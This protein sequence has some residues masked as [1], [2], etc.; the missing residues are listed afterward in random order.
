MAT[1]DVI[2]SRERESQKMS[3]RRLADLS[4]VAET[5]L[6]RIEG[7]QSKSTPADLQKIALALHINPSKLIEAWLKES[8]EGI[9]YNPALL[10]QIRKPDME[11][12]QVEA[13]Y[14]IDQAR[15]AYEKIRSC[16]TGRKMKELKQDTLVEVRVAL[17]NCLGFIDDLKEN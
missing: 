5:N 7:G 11:F 10:S 14:G 1:L 4:T 16:T 15:N 3:R 8:L 17:K 2:I 6:R 12:S 13:M 9:D